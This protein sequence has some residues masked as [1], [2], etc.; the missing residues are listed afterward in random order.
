MK[1]H[2]TKFEGYYVTEDGEIYTEWYR[3]PPRRGEPRKMSQH[4]RGG[5]DPNNRYLA[6]NI[7]LKDESGKTLRQ[8]K[9][10]SH[11]LVAETLIENPQ[12]LKEIDHLDRDKTNNSVSN[13]Q[14]TTHKENQRWM[15]NTYFMKP[16]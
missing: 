15:K 14:W 9:Y 7:S 8:I 5:S 6:V 4:P 10:Y 11:R 12:N 3:N 2:K 16:R 13:L 1:L